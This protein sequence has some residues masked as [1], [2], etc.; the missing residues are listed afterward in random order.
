MVVRDRQKGDSIALY[1]I[2]GFYH[3]N[4]TVELGERKDRQVSISLK[5]R[6]DGVLTGRVTD[7]QGNPLS[8]V[9]VTV[10]GHE[11]E[12][13]TTVVDGHFKV[14]AFAAPGEEVRVSAEAGDLSWNGYLPAG[15]TEEIRLK[16]RNQ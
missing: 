12:G 8:G 1:A 6:T 11:P 2:S 13:F 14:K 16:K 10:L 4:E 9:A 3:G 15:E 7:P 5:K